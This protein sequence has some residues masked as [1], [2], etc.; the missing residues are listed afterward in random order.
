MQVEDRLLREDRRELGAVPG[1]RG[2]SCTI[3]TRP[4]LAADASSASSSSGFSVR[5]SS[6][7]TRASSASASAAR[8]ASGTIAPYATN[9]RSVA[10]A[11]EARLPERDDVLALGNLAAHRPVVELRLEHDDGVGSRIAA[12]SRPFASA[13]VDGIATFTPGVCT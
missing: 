3:T 13:G 8:S 1:V 7:S 11:R 2:A 6:T 5:M 10:L 9:V 12:A 4:V